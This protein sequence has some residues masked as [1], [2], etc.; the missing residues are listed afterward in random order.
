[1]YSYYDDRKYYNQKQ[2]IKRRREIHRQ[3]S[4]IVLTALLLSIFMSVFLF[5]RLTF[6]NS[7]ADFN[8]MH[9]YFTCA[10]IYRNDTLDSFVEKYYSEE[11]ESSDDLKKEI[12]H[13]NHINDDSELIPGNYLTVPYYR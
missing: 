6:A 5:G 7:K 12:M 9:K 13:I 8:E 1:M 4:C 2:V 10:A 3:K 11:W